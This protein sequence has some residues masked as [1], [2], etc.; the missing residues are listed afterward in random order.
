V[1]T[2]FVHQISAPTLWFGYVACINC[3]RN[4]RFYASDGTL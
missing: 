2:D 3:P 4:D 1:Q